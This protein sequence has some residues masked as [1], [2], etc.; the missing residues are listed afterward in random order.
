M[1][2]KFSRTQ[3]LYFTA[4]RHVE[5]IGMEACGAHIFLAGHCE[6]RAMRCG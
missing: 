4:K 3:L 1:R 5:L 6:N 2:K